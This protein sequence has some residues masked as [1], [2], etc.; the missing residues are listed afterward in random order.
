MLYFTILWM[1]RGYPSRPSSTPP[2]SRPVV[3]PLAL[4]L[5]GSAA[6]NLLF[7]VP[8]SGLCEENLLFPPRALPLPHTLSQLIQTQRLHNAQSRPALTPLSATLTKKEGGPKRPPHHLV[9]SPY[10]DF[11][12]STTNRSP[13]THFDPASYF[14]FPI[15]SFSLVYCT[16]ATLPPM[17][18]TFMSL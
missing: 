11:R 12:R 2:S 4:S 1:P 7:S 13:Q 17:K 6:R 16:S 3:I 8:P 10:F 15:S 9:L 18:V 14:H 5:E